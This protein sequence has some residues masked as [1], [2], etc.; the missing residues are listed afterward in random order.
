MDYVVK[1]DILVDTNI[2]LSSDNYY[3]NGI[4]SNIS[5]IDKVD[6]GRLPKDDNEIVL[7]IYAGDYY[8]D[9]KDD[10]LNTEY[11]VEQLSNDRVKYKVKIVGLKY[12]TEIYNRIYYVT[13][14]FQN[15]ISENSN[16]NI[17]LLNIILWM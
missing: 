10:L 9:Y 15:D 12:G 7:E 4:V 8:M 6:Y 5:L 14:K 11:I 3:F 17:V 13:D 2:E 1:N 16:K